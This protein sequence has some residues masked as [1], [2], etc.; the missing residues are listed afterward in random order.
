MSRSLRPL[1]LGVLALLALAACSDDS[2]GPGAADARQESLDLAVTA[3]DAIASNV[4]MARSDMHAAGASGSG[5]AQARVGDGCTWNAG[6]GS[7]TCESS[8]E[9][10][11]DVSRT[12]TF[13]AGGATQQQYDAAT[14]DSIRITASMA[15]TFTRDGRTTTVSRSRAAVISG[16]AGAETQRTINATGT[17]SVQSQFVDGDVTRSYSET[18]SNVEDDVVIPV[19][20]GYPLS[21]TVTHDIT[22]TM[23]VTGGGRTGTRTVERHVVVTFNGTSTVPMT[24]GTLECTL[25]LE[26]RRASCAR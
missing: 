1:T 13:Y 14:T 10:D 18:V 24:V 15:G 5:G 4:M 8:R 20:G 9:S 3:G 2:T 26:T 11:V 16:L 12:I 17:G 22:A 25:N 6:A 7:W 21:G 19:G 23:T